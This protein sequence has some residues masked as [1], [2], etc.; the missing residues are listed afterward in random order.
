MLKTKPYR[1]TRGRDTGKDFILTEMPASQAFKWGYRALGAMARSGLDVPPHIIEMGMAGVLAMGLKAILGADFA[2]AEPL[3]DELM[4][5][6]RRVEEKLPDGRP[7]VENDIEEPIT[8]SL[9]QSEVLELHTGFSVADYLSKTWAEAGER[10]RQRDAL[11][12][13]PTSTE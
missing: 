13:I 8:I 7:L 10:A 1:A 4:A 6:V 2:D 5:C 3:L 11:R 9:L 12:N